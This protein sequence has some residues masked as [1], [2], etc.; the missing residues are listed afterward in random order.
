MKKNKKDNSNGLLNKISD[1]YNKKMK[2][3][4]L[5]F[6]IIETIIIILIVFGLGLVIGGIVMYGKGSIANSSM[7]FNEFISAY[8]EIV[9]N[10]YQ[11][12]DKDK[13]LEAGI[14]G[15]VG[16]LGDPY[17]TYM[18]KEA[19]DDFNEDVDGTYQGIGAE[20]RYND[21]KKP[22]IGKVFEK[23][24][25]ETVGLKENDVILMVNGES[26]DGKTLSDIA[27]VVKGKNGTKVNITISRDGEEKTFTITRG[28]VD[29]ISV[30]SE[31]IEKN[32]KKIG[33][34]YI[35]VFAGNTTKQFKNELKSLE[36]QNID[37][38]IID[39]RGNTG[40]YLTTVTDIVSMFMQ[41]GQPIYQLK[42]KGNVEI[43]YDETE[44]Y[45]EYPVVVLAD[46]ASASASELLV[47]AFKETY[48]SQIIGTKTFG[49]GRVQ[50]ISTLSS[51]AMFKYT[52]QEWL[53]PNGN[54][55]DQAGIEPDIE[56]KYVYDEKIDNQKDKAI[57]EIS[58]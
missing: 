55:I 12:V 46:G 31:V 11:E 40:G 54:Y 22:T 41:K 34:I 57:E 17:S 10:Y 50:K 1:F 48:H 16:Y 19:A 26:V 20:I 9:D 5:K 43:V 29:N 30:I 33:Y 21:D 13:L 44:E 8:N 37:S 47:G 3:S 4:K 38:L 15:M 39:V 45:R 27:S 14:S 23:S 36:D 32:D 52:Y 2:K 56:I 28:V 18:S 6:N 49:K 51:G 24:P 42:T 25:A 7:S 58:K 53:T 35:S